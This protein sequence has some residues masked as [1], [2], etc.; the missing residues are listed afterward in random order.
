MKTN[1]SPLCKKQ[2]HQYLADGQHH[3]NIQTFTRKRVEVNQRKIV[4]FLKYRSCVKNIQSEKNVTETSL[5]LG[6][7]LA[8][9][10]LN[11]KWYPKTQ[12]YG[13]CAYLTLLQFVY[14]D[15]YP[16][17]DMRLYSHRKFVIETLKNLSFDSSKMQPNFEKVAIFIENQGLGDFKSHKGMPKETGLWPSSDELVS[18][19]ILVETLKYHVWELLDE[20]KDNRYRAVGINKGGTGHLLRS[21]SDY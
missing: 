14:E 11:D 10:N 19:D 8:R 13:F 6:L 17:L 5:H 16:Y 15:T 20:K 9:T 4:A 7:S 18:N 2:K 3:H 21:N 1:A 12:P